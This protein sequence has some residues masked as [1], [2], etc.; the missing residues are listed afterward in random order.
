[1]IGATSLNHVQEDLAAIGDDKQLSAEEI[2]VLRKLVFG[3][4]MKEEL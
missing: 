1:M 2:A 3:N 4:F